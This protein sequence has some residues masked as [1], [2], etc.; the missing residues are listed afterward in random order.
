MLIDDSCVGKYISSIILNGGERGDIISKII[1]IVENHSSFINDFYSSGKEI[2]SS[3]MINCVKLLAYQFGS[4]QGGIDSKIVIQK[5]RYKNWNQLVFNWDGFTNKDSQGYF[6]IGSSYLNII[7][8]E[9]T[10]DYEDIIDPE[11]IIQDEKD[12]DYDY[13]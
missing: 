9:D 2:D 3:N 10:R 7:Y 1:Q 6:L 8:E 12:Q 5:Y 13:D 11:N 4:I